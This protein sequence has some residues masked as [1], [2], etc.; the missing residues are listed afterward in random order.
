MTLLTPS[1]SH[2]HTHTQLWDATLHCRKAYHMREAKPQSRN[3]SVRSVAL[4]HVGNTILV[5][6]QGSEIYEVTNIQVG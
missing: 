1:S 5:G 2:T 3:V 4:N 6:T